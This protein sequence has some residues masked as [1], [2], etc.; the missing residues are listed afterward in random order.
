MPHCVANTRLHRAPRP[1]RKRRAQYQRSRFSGDTARL[2]SAVVIYYQ[3]VDIAMRTD[4]EDDL[5]NACRFV[6]R[7]ND[8]EGAGMSL[9]PWRVGRECGPAAA[10]A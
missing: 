8:N 5:T 9:G 6:F 7:G 2:V 3:H 4:G 1:L 10:V